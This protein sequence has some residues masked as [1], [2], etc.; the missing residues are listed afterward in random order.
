MS[1]PMDIDTRQLRRVRLGVGE[2]GFGDPDLPL[3]TAAV[4][5]VETTGL[6]PASDKVIELAVRR[7]RYD[8]RGHIVEIGK[9][10]CWREDPGVPL[11]DDIVR[12]TGITD[13]DLLGRRIDDRV[14]TD[15]I[16]S[17]DV[18]IAHNAAFDR[19]MVE[20]RLTRLPPMQWACSCREIDWAA[21]GF[22]GRS[23]GWLCAQA[24]WF[25]DAH[26]AEGDVDALIQ[27]LRHERTDGWPLLYELDGSSSRDSFLI[28]AV[29]SAFSTKD[30]LRMR[31]YRWDPKEQ[32]WWRE[33]F[34]GDLVIEEAWLA[35]EV[36]AGGKGAKSIGPR[37]TRRDA[38]SRYR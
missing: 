19:P 18:V 7:F 13:Q 5:D 3:R 25:Y 37:I 24:G 15:V 38:Y 11:P 26:R 2:T 1:D 35:N 16:A 22:E 9:S 20:Q 34:E 33:V 36:Y 17:A 31:G 21:A 23:L 14:A 28:A 30:A 8:T 29:G 27:L 10:W 4:I 32:V 6:D 12:I